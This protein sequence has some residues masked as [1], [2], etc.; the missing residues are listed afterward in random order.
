MNTLK[1]RNYRFLQIKRKFS[2][3]LFIVIN[4]IANIEAYLQ[5]T[6][7]LELIYSRTFLVL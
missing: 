2:C 7:P 4:N 1:E 5:N 3:E 6:L